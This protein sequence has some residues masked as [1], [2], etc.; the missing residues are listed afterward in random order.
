MIDYKIQTIVTEEVYGTANF[1][2]DRELIVDQYPRKWQ[3][4]TKFL[5]LN[6]IYLF[7]LQSSDKVNDGHFTKIQCSEKISLHH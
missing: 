3:N 5:Y 6:I 1:C 7:R 4:L 2:S